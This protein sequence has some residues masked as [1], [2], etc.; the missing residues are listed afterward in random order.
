MNCAE[1]VSISCMNKVI[2]IGIPEDYNKKY[3]E[4]D[5]LI[6]SKDL[7]ENTVRL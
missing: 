3:T 5:A 4:Y 1:E 7:L 2:E 6:W